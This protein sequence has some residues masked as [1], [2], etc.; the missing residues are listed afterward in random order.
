MDPP[1]ILNIAL[2]GKLICLLQSVVLPTV[3]VPPVILVTVPEV[4]I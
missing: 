4:T 2:A 1:Q 3:N